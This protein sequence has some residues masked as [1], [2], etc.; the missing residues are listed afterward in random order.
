MPLYMFLHSLLNVLVQIVN[1]MGLQ[2]KNYGGNKIHTSRFPDSNYKRNVS[3]RS[4]THVNQS[5]P[6]QI[7]MKCW[8]IL[9]HAPCVEEGQNVSTVALRVVRGDEKGNLVPGGITAPLFLRD[10]NKGTWKYRLRESQMRQWSVVMD[11]ARLG[12]VSDCTK[13]YRSVLSLKRAPYVK[14]QAIVQQKN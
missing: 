6:A 2:K 11:P 14:N 1:K 10:T 9:S 12:P 5:I 3:I 13:N 4:S 7:F 8:Q